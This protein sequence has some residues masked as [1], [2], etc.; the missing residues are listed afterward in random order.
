MEPLAFVISGI[1][2]AEVSVIIRS[3][4]LR[5][6]TL[7][8]TL[9]MSNNTKSESNNCFIIHCFSGK[10]N[11]DKQFQPVSKVVLIADVNHFVFSENLSSSNF[12]TQVKSFEVEERN[13]QT[14]NFLRRQMPAALLL[15]IM[16]CARNLQISELSASRLF[17]YL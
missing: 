15:E 14:T 17:T 8:E 5:L 12:S 9:I 13:R 3:R 16:H 6:I 7:I 10:E 11:N 1:I 2:K 4:R